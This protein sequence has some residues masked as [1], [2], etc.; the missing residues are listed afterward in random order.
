MKEYAILVKIKIDS[1]DEE[2]ALNVADILFRN[3]NREYKYLNNKKGICAKPIAVM[4]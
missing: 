2:T 3:I 1:N 4:R